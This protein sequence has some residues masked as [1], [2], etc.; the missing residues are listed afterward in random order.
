MWSDRRERAKA[1]HNID[2]VIDVSRQVEIT[3]KNNLQAR[4]AISKAGGESVYTD[5][6]KRTLVMM[7]FLGSYSMKFVYYLN[8][9]SGF[10]VIFCLCIGGAMGAGHSVLS[11]RYVFPFLFYQTAL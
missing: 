1:W 2:P 3:V 6:A 4:E 5:F 10:K 7:P 11:N 9:L 8:L